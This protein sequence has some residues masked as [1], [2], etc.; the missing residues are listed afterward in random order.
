MSDDD[1]HIPHLRN[2]DLRPLHQPRLSS[3]WTV[4][5]TGQA[6]QRAAAQAHQQIK[7]RRASGPSPDREG[8]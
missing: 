7:L 3:W 6:F 4:A 8:R 5:E 1:L 2:L